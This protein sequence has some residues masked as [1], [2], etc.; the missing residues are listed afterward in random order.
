MERTMKRFNQLEY[1]TDCTNLNT[2]H[3]NVRNTERGFMS[4]LSDALSIIDTNAQGREKGLSVVE[5]GIGGGGSHENWSNYLTNDCTV[6]GVDLF[7]KD[8]YLNYKNKIPIAQDYYLHAFDRLCND[9]DQSY[10]MLITDRGRPGAPCKIWHGVDAYS[11]Q[12]IDLVVNHNKLLADF[13]LDDADTHYNTD[14]MDCWK[15]AI[16][17]TGALF[18]STIL[19]NGTSQ[20]MALHNDPTWVAEQYQILAQAGYIVFDLAEYKRDIITIGDP[21]HYMVMYAKDYNLFEE[22][23][24]KYQHNIVDGEHNWRN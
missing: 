14:S 9:Q 5:L 15:N 24:I 13:V 20:A 18:S 10:R 19:G 2:N 7:S 22:L 21:L 11:Q 8:H 1:L 4:F 3:G 6:Y 17:E 23:L 12:A 16:A